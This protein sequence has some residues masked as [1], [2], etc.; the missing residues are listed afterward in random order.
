MYLHLVVLNNTV[1]VG[2]YTIHGWEGNGMT[3]THPMFSPIKFL[4]FGGLD[5]MF[6]FGSK[7]FSTHKMWLE[8]PRA[9]NPPEE[10]RLEPENTGPLEKENHLNQTIIFRFELS[11]FGGVYKNG[12]T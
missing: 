6:F 8:S 2:K 12:S 5:G 11:I 9:T 3:Y 4:R 7:F 1:N 10:E